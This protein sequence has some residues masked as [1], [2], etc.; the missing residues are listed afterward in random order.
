MVIDLKKAATHKHLEDSM[1]V[2]ETAK[3][4]GRQITKKARVGWFICWPAVRNE[5]SFV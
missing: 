2:I 5:F 1:Q 4:H 3:T